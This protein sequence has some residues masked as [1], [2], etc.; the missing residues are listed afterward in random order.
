MFL[1]FLV[2]MSR[3]SKGH[4]S[5]LCSQSES[6]TDK[7]QR[8]GAKNSLAATLIKQESV[9]IQEPTKTQETCQTWR[10]HSAHLQPLQALPNPIPWK[11]T[12]EKNEAMQQHGCPCC[13]SLVISFM[14]A[15]YNSTHPDDS[16]SRKK[17]TREKQRTSSGMRQRCVIIAVTRRDCVYVLQVNRLL[18]ELLP[19]NIYIL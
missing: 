14:K 7:L 10:A 15:I 19:A 3:S 18:C 6:K 9:R 1:L 12:R 4:F 2:S 17:R 11:P 8:R 16:K 13:P 5:H